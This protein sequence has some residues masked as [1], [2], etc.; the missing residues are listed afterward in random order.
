M[1][2]L[3]MAYPP[4]KILGIIQQF[5][6][7]IWS[8][9]VYGMVKGCSLSTERTIIQKDIYEYDIYCSSLFCFSAFVHHWLLKKIQTINKHSQIG[10]FN[11]AY[12]L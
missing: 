7:F 9:K 10:A 3:E 1:N 11:P 2:A 8:S 6:H 5:Q 4:V 12:N